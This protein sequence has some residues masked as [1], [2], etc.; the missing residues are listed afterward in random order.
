MA[1]PA[2]RLVVLAGML[3]SNQLYFTDPGPG[4]VVIIT[5][6]PTVPLG[7]PAHDSGGDLESPSQ[8]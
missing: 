1:A 4:I 7:A 3:Y 6:K 2:V 8:V 5:A